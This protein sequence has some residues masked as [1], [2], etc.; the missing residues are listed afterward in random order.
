[1]ETGASYVRWLDDGEQ[2]GGSRAEGLV[3][4]HGGRKGGF[5]LAPTRLNRGWRRWTT[6]RKLHTGMVVPQSGP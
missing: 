3:V 1:M 2:G 6:A 4:R 5:A